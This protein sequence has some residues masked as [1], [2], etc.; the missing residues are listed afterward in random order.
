[1]SQDATALQ[2]AGRERCNRQ[3]RERYVLEE[4]E[5]PGADVRSRGTRYRMHA[6]A[7]TDRGRYISWREVRAAKDRTLTLRNED[8]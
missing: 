6:R 2:L 7:G 5:C 4:V 3:E 1:M 8:S